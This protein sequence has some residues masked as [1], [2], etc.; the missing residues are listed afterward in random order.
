[1][2]RLRNCSVT[3]SQGLLFLAAMLLF[4]ACGEIQKL[5][6]TEDDAPSS[7]V[8]RKA[9]SDDPAYHAGLLNTGQLLQNINMASWIQRGFHGR[10]QTIAILD[11]G[12]AGLS[13][14]RGKHLPPDLSV[15][16]GPIDNEGETLHGTKLAEVIFA[17]TSGSPNWSERS[18]HPNIKLYNA[19]GFTN[20]SAAVDQAIKDRVDMIVY[21]QVWEF[22][23]NFDGRGFINAAVNKATS[24]G[25]LWI[26]AAGNYAT[27]SWQG[28]LI[29]NPDYTARLPFES[30]Y[31]RMVVNEPSTPVKIILSWN[32][33]SDSKDWRTTR[34]LDLVLLDRNGREIASARKIQDGIDHGRSPDYSAHARESLETTLEPG[35]YLLR[36]DIRSNNFDMN[37]RIRIAANGPDISFVDQSTDASIMIPA[38]NPTVL[39]VGASDDSSSSFG[40]TSGG[41]QK[42]EVLAPSI[43]QFENEI[44][45]QGSSS[46]AAVAAAAIAVFRDACGS[47]TRNLLVQRINDGFLSQASNYSRVLWLPPSGQCR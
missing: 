41:A 5:T 18:Q 33:F 47:V 12:F 24:A 28:P 29:P 9:E 46:A 27:S 7:E 31:V 43:L 10:S 6:R 42:P 30:R 17:M 15:F 14:S 3:V 35:I 36:V 37:S 1:M 32:D 19:N 8:T 2:P 38:D 39:T 34:N 40:R 25:I 11:N 44:S 20:F 22:G 13:V 23:G 21:S 45:F 16:K 26:N 4:G